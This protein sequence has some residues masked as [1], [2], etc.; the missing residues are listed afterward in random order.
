[1]IKMLS[2]PSL[3]KATG[4]AVKAFYTPDQN[5]DHVVKL[6]VS[7]WALT[8]RIL[9]DSAPDF[10]G[11]VDGKR[12]IAYIKSGMNGPFVSVLLAGRVGLS[13]SRER[14]GA[15]RVR[16]GRDGGLELPLQLVGAS[17]KIVLQGSSRLPVPLIMR[18]G[19]GN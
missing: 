7:R 17:Q 5:I 3:K 18:M 16:F 1:M 4:S 9:S 2:R 6:W 14:V 11:E 12:V 19:L 10:D 13:G 15:G 8:Q